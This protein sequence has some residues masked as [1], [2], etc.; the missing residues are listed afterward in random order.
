MDWT[1]SSINIMDLI[2][3]GEPTITGVKI[4]N[5][6]LAES[7]LCRNHSKAFRLRGSDYA[8]SQAAIQ[9]A[10]I[11]ASGSNLDQSLIVHALPAS[12]RRKARRRGWARLRITTMD[13]PSDH[14]FTGYLLF[15]SR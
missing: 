4:N 11:H 14:G 12:R 6:L 3:I 1:L 7:H 5:E 8:L 15:A 13:T 9:I 10:L 2:V